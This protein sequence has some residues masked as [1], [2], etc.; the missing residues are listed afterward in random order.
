MYLKYSDSKRFYVRSGRKYLI[1]GI[2]EDYSDLISEN[3]GPS[4]HFTFVFNTF[5]M[6]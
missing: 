4:R 5:V 3:I 2:D 6:L 1:N